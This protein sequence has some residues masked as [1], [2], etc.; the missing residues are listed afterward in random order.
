MVYILTNTEEAYVGQTTSVLN[1]MDQHGANPEKQAFTH[2]NLI[3]SDAFNMSVIT[4]YEHRLIQL[5]N[6]DGLYRLTNKNEGLQDSDYYCKE[7]YDEM[8]QQ[9]WTELADYNLVQHTIE[10]LEESE[11]FKYSPYKQLNVEQEAAFSNIL[12]AVTK[13]FSGGGKP[14]PIVA[15]GMPGTGKTVLAVFLLKALR[16]SKD[17]GHLNVKILE[18]MTALKATL[19]DSLKGVYGL[20]EG[21]IIGPS[22]LASTKAGFVSGEKG[23]YDIL[24]VDEA[25]KLKGRRNIQNYA[26]FDRTSTALGLDKMTCTQVDWVLNQAKFPI[27]FY[28]PFQSISRSGVTP[29][30]FESSVGEAVNKPIHLESQMRVKGGKGYLEYICAILHNGNPESRTFPEYEFEMHQDFASFYASFQQTLSNSR[31]TRM[32]AGF[33]WE[34]LTNPK[35]KLKA[36]EMP[37]EYDIS[38]EG[39]NLRWNR[40]NANWVGIGTKDPTAAQEVGCIHS[41]QDYDLSYAYVI[42]GNELGY[43]RKAQTLKVNRSAYKDKNGKNATEDTDLLSYIQ[44]IYYVLL[45]RG[46]NGTH[47]Y[48]C[49][50]DLRDYL[51]RFFPQDR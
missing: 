42:F 35:R 6:A 12:A 3:Y 24:L 15:E 16:D 26:D 31:L 49:D 27:F 11:V 22:D 14:A 28:D 18:P 51:S 13:S 19:Q 25:H 21:D 47:I 44:N 45:T 2:T 39:F 20:S 48:V 34:W 30:E 33:S 46:I 7:E 36:G 32:V 43:D 29:R 9:L 17:F 10:Q 50:P 8:F 1:R 38:I 4:D 37:A 41:I 40:K 23:R 5:M